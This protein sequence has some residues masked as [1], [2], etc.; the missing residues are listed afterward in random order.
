MIPLQ[1]QMVEQILIK[2][3][4]VDGIRENSLNHWLAE[5]EEDDPVYCGFPRCEKHNTF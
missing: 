3:M 2:R 4:T 5:S 1:C